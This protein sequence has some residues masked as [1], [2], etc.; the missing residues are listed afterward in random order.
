MHVQDQLGQGNHPPKVY[1]VHQSLAVIAYRPTFP[2]IISS[3]VISSYSWST[4]WRWFKKP[5][6][7]IGIGGKQLRNFLSFFLGIE[8]VGDTEPDDDAVLGVPLLPR[9]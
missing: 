5:F 8:S 4:L 1:A 3:N 2:F 6:S 7:G 9:A